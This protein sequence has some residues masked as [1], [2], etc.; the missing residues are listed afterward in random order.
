MAKKEVN[1]RIKPI[2]LRDTES[3][4]E[5]TLEFNRESVKFAESR[6]FKIDDVS[7]YPMTK[8]PEFF[9]YAFRAHHKNVSREKTDKMIFEEWGGIGSLPEGLV[10]RLF[11]LYTEPFEATKTEEER[12]NSKLTVEL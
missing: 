7:D 12:K 4:T 6:G 11:Q 8:I 10:E 5:Y 2:I 9:Y 1:E 3:G